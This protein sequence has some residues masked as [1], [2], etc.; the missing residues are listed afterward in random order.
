M[1][2]NMENV[3]MNEAMDVE[4][5]GSN[6][7]GKILAGV[8]ITGAAVGV[9]HAVRKGVKKFKNWRAAKKAKKETTDVACEEYVDV[10]DEQ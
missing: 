10:T 2:E 6:L 7:G 8:L 5:T 3:A 9:G 4:S 1:N